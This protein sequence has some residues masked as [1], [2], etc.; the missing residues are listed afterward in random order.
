M[1]CT[2]E[3]DP[4][5]TRVR[6]LKVVVQEVNGTRFKHNPKTTLII[7]KPYKGFLPLLRERHQTSLTYGWPG[8]ML[9][10]PATVEVVDHR[11]SCSVPIVISHSFFYVCTLLQSQLHFHTRAIISSPKVTT[12]PASRPARSTDDGAKRYQKRR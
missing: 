6:I 10:T 5:H 11:R 7:W 4:I 8:P 3:A 9:T 1:G 12:S 2:N